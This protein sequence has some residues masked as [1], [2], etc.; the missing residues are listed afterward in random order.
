MEVEIYRRGLTTTLRQISKVRASSRPSLGC[1]GELVSFSY[2]PLS[3]VES[4][5]LTPPL[6]YF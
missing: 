6:G 1:L 5:G 2:L 4:R 3:L